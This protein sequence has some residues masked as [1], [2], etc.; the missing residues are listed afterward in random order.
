MP[1]LVGQ[2]LL[3]CPSWQQCDAI[4]CCTFQWQP[5]LQCCGKNFRL[6]AVLLVILSVSQL[7]QGPC[8]CIQRAGSSSKI[9]CS[10]TQGA[11]CVAHRK[12]SSWCLLKQLH[13]N[14]SHDKH[15]EALLPFH[16]D[17]NC[18]HCCVCHM[19]QEHTFPRVVWS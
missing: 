5:K 14:L 3:N 13:R 1:S 9:T 15:L 18:F 12:E 2:Q 19:N 10:R 6:C 17:V 7:L 8:Y 4:A 11:E 16:I